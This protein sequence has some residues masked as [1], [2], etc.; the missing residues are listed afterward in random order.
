MDKPKKTM[1]LKLSVRAA[2]YTALLAGGFG[3]GSALFSTVFS[4][5]AQAAA[6]HSAA[7]SLNGESDSLYTLGSPGNPD[8]SVL[9]MAAPEDS[10]VETSPKT[11]S[12]ADSDSAD[13]SESDS[14]AGDSAADPGEEENTDSQTDDTEGDSSTADEQKEQTKAETAGSEALSAAGEQALSSAAASLESA[15][16]TDDLGYP[17]LSSDEAIAKTILI[18]AG[19][20]GND[21][22]DAASDGTMEKNITLQMARAIKQHLEIQDP[23]LQ[24]I[25]LRDGDTIEGASSSGGWEDLTARRQIME[26]VDAD[27][28]LSLHAHDEDKESG[29]YSFFINPDD[30]IAASLCSA[31]E[32]N[33]KKEG[34]GSAASLTTTDQYPLLLVSTASSH[35]A[36]LNLGVPSVES[37]LKR[38][39]DQSSMEHGAAAIAAAIASTIQD[40]PDAPNYV[41][42]ARQIEQKAQ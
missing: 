2:L 9:A 5:P 41:S 11:D 24:V 20:G 7:L 22:G 40:N 21:T 13:G 31:I 33:L 32:T 17:I 18:D 28:F 1:R 6:V 3:A 10:Q 34:W 19:H 27:Y 26:T 16:V 14:S 8:S 30:P 29:G 42:K 12:T 25:L 39:E 38:L 35:S 23:A 36:Q 37:D 4:A 15:A